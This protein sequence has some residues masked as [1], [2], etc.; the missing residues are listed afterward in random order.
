[1]SM[2]G[3]GT[4]TAGSGGGDPSVCLPRDIC[5]EPF[6]LAS[7]LRNG[8]LLLKGGGFS[9]GRQGLSWLSTWIHLVPPFLEER[10]DLSPRALAPQLLPNPCSVY[11]QQFPDRGLAK[12]PRG[13]RC[14]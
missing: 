5:L 7:D 11:C 4:D 14:S 1:M 3:P 9:L 6:L 2:G 10:R 13:Q 8:F 12:R